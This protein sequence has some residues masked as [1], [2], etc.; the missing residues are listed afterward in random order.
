MGWQQGMYPEKIAE[1]RVS[2]RVPAYQSGLAK[3]IPL[4]LIHSPGLKR[5]G[6]NI[7]LIAKIP[8]SE[9]IIML[10]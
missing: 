1:K 3:V 2:K 10:N 7:P 5:K 9:F 6:G 8:E 4:F